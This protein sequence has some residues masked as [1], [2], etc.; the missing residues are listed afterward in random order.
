[1]IKKLLE[2]GSD[3]LI[4][5]IKESRGIWLSESDNSNVDLIKIQ[6]HQEI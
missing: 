6:P 4:A 5:A 2:E 1:M 3:T